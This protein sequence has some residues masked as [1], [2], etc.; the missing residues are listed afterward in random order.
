MVTMKHIAARV[1]VSVSAVSLVLSGRDRGR[2]NAAT[3]EE[4]RRV[5]DELGYVPNQLARSLKMRKSR[6]IGLVSDRVASVPFSG[7]MLGGAQEVAWA[8]GFMLM[9]IDTGGNE[10]VQTA[11]VRSLLE[12]DVEA[13]IIATDFHRRVKI[14]VVPLTMPIVLLDGEPDGE[15]QSTVD[16]VVPD[17]ERGAYA[18]V[19]LLLEAGHR[20]IGFVNVT[21]YPFATGQRGDGY[22][23]ALTDAGVAVDPQLTVMAPAA[24]TAHAIE[25]AMKLLDRQDRPTAVFCFSDQTAMGVYQVARRLGLRIPE[26]LSVAGFDNQEF[27]ADSL[28]PGLTTVQLPHWE[29]GKWAMRRALDRLED[30]REQEPPMGCRMP[31]RPVL[32]NSIGPPPTP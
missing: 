32:R 5:A 29:M 15:T 18:A 12:R 9:L 6:T 4:I 26:D 31:C 2:V 21:S 20:R 16:F 11:A 22:R 23:R 19:R 24:A 25:P 3:A 30:A 7:H 14:P 27:V 13:M 10:D 17:E 28:D 1:G 8:A